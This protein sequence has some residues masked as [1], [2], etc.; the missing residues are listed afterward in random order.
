MGGGGASPDDGSISTAT[1]GDGHGDGSG[2]VRFN[3]ASDSTQNRI[4]SFESDA[5]AEAD[6]DTG[7]GADDGEFGDWQDFER[8]DEQFLEHGDRV[9]AST[10]NGEI[11]GEIAQNG[12]GDLYGVDTDDG[13]RHTIESWD[14]DRYQT[15]VDDLDDVREQL[16]DHFEKKG[17]GSNSKALESYTDDGEYREY[18]DQLR[19][20]SEVAEQSPMYDD[21]PEMETAS[22]ILATTDE[23]TAR[24]MKN[25]QSWAETSLPEE[26]TVHRGI[27]VDADDFLERAEQ[28]QEDGDVIM[29]AG[30]QSATIE[31]DVSEGFG[32]VT[33]DIDTDHGVYVRAASQHAGEDEVLLPAGTQFEV[34]EV[35]HETNTVSVE[36]Q[37][38]F[39][40]DAVDVSP[41]R[42]RIQDD[43]MSYP[44]AINDVI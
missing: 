19:S 25:I 18:Q 44:E 12:D 29:D 26:M 24:E 27:D 11:I 10:D 16:R 9:T 3:S 17:V 41:I 37:G 31:Q 39:D 33:L 43:G 36:A 42:D 35:D 40:L 34:N 20:A 22:A 1:D 15:R 23:E 14:I 2:S 38:G 21:H 28:A 32:N 13:E 30:F 4:E 5:E 7:T 6:T 8:G